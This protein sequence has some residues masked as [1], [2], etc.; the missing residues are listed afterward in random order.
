[1]TRFLICFDSFLFSQIFFEPMTNPVDQFFCQV[2]LKTFDRS[3]KK[4]IVPDFKN[5]VEN[6]SFGLTASNFFVTTD[7]GWKSKHSVAWDCLA[8]LIWVEL[9][10]GEALGIKKPWASKSLDTL[11]LKVLYGDY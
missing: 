11:R 6:F 7:P 2:F 4:K 10:Q 9:N 5:L 1:M 8:W 3:F